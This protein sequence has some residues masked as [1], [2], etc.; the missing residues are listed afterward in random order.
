LARSEPL[1]PYRFSGGTLTLTLRVQPGASRSGWAGRYGEHALRLR[2]AAPA[3]AGKAN[4]ACVRFLAGAF[5][6]PLSQVR[7]LRG[8]SGRDKTVEIRSVPA[9]RWNAFREQWQSA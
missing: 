6:V 7:I 2:L 8:A 9:D 1:A 5:A 4:E 3:V